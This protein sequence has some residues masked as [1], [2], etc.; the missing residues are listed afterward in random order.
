MLVGVALSDFRVVGT[1]DRALVTVLWAMAVG[2]PVHCWVVGT[3]LR[4]RWVSGCGLGVGPGWVCVDQVVIASSSQA[5]SGLSQVD[6][7]RVAVASGF[8]V[9]AGAK[10][11]WC[12]I[13]A[14]EAVAV[15]L[16]SA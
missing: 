15:L 7:Y 9:Q 3:G 16:W 10:L 6:V 11:G 5:G 14:E 4:L 2:S 13:L 8:R 1:G 12:G